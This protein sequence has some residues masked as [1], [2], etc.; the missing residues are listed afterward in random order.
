[1][2]RLEPSEPEEMRLRLVRENLLFLLDEVSQRLTLAN[3]PA[4]ALELLHEASRLHTLAALS[5]LLS[6]ADTREF[7]DRL[8]QAGGVRAQLLG[9]ARQRALHQHRLCC[10][11]LLDPLL[12][13]VATGAF[14]L[15]RRIA[16]VAPREPILDEEYEEDFWYAHALHMLVS[17][18]V[19]ELPA[20]IER[21]EVALAGMAAP[22]LPMLK[23]LSGRD[24]RRFDAGLEQMIEEREQYFERKRGTL[25]R[26]AMAYATERHIFLEGAAL[27]VLAEQ[28]GL[29]T[30]REYRFIPRIARQ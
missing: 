18:S 25:V 30:R 11:S 8:L 6:E 13:C 1:M 15:A 7:R 10:A 27:L 29:K 24:Q 17:G 28:A 22:R 26:D 12:G 2:L 9:F 14:D 23:G 19:R 5:S 4:V 3:P 20:A 16:E 21:F